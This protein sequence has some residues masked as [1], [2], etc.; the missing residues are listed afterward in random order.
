MLI[1]V[2]GTP[3]ASKT[4]NT[5]KM[6]NE[7]PEFKDKPIYYHY[8]KELTFDWTELEDPKEWHKL[9]AGSVI[10]I[11]ECHKVFPTRSASSTPPEHV[12]EIAEYRHKGYVIILIT[13][14]PNDVDNFVRRRL[15]VHYHLKRIN[16][17][18]F[19]RR[20]M[21]NEY[22][23]PD[24]RSNLNA[25]VE[26]ETIRIDKK[27]FGTYKSAESHTFKAK[28][29]KRILFYL[30]G[31]L[32]MIAIAF[33]SLMT[34]LFSKAAE[35]EISTAGAPQNVS[36]NQTVTGFTGNPY[37]ESRYQPRIKTLP[38]SAPVYDDLF[39]VVSSPDVHCVSNNHLKCICY[40]QQLIK[41][42]YDWQ[43][44]KAV[45]AGRFDPTK[46]DRDN[47][48]QQQEFDSFD[49]PF[50]NDIATEEAL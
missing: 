27:Y 12:Q 2:T 24:S 48:F 32:A 3:G 43:E 30:G 35:S 8:I 40:D 25:A 7:N 1:M 5:I 14:H 11:D 4:L 50:S 10:V 37:D 44:C 47:T 6:V 19:V 16:Q 18:N 33:Y 29:P 15:N 45:M 28:F 23:N 22:M 39:K 31:G 17:S 38:K 41:Y 34:G 36:Y 21:W 20:F 42:Q 13:Q 26:E 9:P 49:L 46:P